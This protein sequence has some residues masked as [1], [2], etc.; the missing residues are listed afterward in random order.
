[1]ESFHL[2]Q[3][4]LQILACSATPKVGMQTDGQTNKLSL[5]TDETTEVD[6][7]TQQNTDSM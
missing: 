2:Q 1:M 6:T 4:E 7:I 3:G 5:W